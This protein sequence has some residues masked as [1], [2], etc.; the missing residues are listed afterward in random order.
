MLI[1]TG[2]S[3]IEYLMSYTQKSYQRAKH[4]ESL[5][6]I[7]QRWF[8]TECIQQYLGKAQGMYLKIETCTRL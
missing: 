6:S 8:T 1:T 5:I 2:I 7:M 3:H 4:G